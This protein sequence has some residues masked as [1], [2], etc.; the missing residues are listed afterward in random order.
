M[1]G[2]D[3]CLDN[4]SQYW[5]LQDPRAYNAQDTLYRAGLQ[6]DY[7]V[8]NDIPLNNTKVKNIDN[9]ICAYI[10]SQKITYYSHY[11]SDNTLRRFVYSGVGIASLITENLLCHPFVVLR[12]QCQVILTLFYY[13]KN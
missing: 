10:I 2:L 6:E 4:Y 3:D 8:P 1:A 9:G 5:D 12:R 11:I 13:F 7:S